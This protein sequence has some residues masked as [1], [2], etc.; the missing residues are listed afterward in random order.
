MQFQLSDV[1]TDVLLLPIKL[2]YVG[3]KR[4]DCI[5]REAVALL[6]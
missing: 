5:A 3:M 6:K 1:Q 2:I 4:G